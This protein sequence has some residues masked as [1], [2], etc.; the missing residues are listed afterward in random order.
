MNKSE[1]IEGVL[2]SGRNAGD[3]GMKIFSEFFAQWLAEQDFLFQERDRPIP[4]LE[5]FIPQLTA[6]AAHAFR[7]S[8]EP[9]FA[10][11]RARYVTEVG[12]DFPDLIELGASDYNTQ[13][14][15][16][17][18]IGQLLSGIDP[19]RP[20]IERQW[21]GYAE[22]QRIA[23][24]TVFDKFLRLVYR[25]GLREMMQRADGGELQGIFGK[26]EFLTSRSQSYVNFGFLSHPILGKTGM[27]CTFV[28][29]D[30]DPLA[31]GA[32]FR[33]IRANLSECLQLINDVTDRWPDDKQMQQELLEPKLDLHR[34]IAS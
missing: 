13:Q 19:D 16:A 9:R 32:G 28:G 31:L 1:L 14:M 7:T 33:I 25:C 10:M 26:T 20:Y 8:E 34:R 15:T 11:A 23:L 2:R 18:L 27:K 4:A 6:D 17:R 24:Q 3:K 12:H 30:K 21:Q 29:L 22:S 5:R